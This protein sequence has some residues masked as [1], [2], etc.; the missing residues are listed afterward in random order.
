M[1]KGMMI[2]IIVLILIIGSMTV[3]AKQILKTD[4]YIF[5]YGDDAKHM[6]VY[7]KRDDGRYIYQGTREWPL[8]QWREAITL[9]GTRPGVEI[10]GV[11]IS[12][13]DV[14]A[15]IIAYGATPKPE[16]KPE[17]VFDYETPQL[18]EIEFPPTLEKEDKE[19]LEKAKITKQEMDELNQ[20]VKSI[21]DE[22]AEIEKVGD[23]LDTFLA[24]RPAQIEKDYPESKIEHLSPEERDALIN[25]VISATAAAETAA[26]IT[27]ETEH[28][29]ETGNDVEP[30]DTNP[31]KARELDT[32]SPASPARAAE[33]NTKLSEAD[34]AY[35]KAETELNAAWAAYDPKK[36]ETEK[37]WKD[38]VAKFNEAEEEKR[39]ADVAAQDAQRDLAKKEK[40]SEDERTAEAAARTQRIAEGQTAVGLAQRDAALDGQIYLKK[41]EEKAKERAIDAAEKRNDEIEVKKLEA[42]LEK[43]NEER[44]KLEK[45][46]KDLSEAQVDYGK[47]VQQITDL[48]SNIDALKG[49][50]KDKAPGE[51]EKANN[52]LKAAA[53]ISDEISDLEKQLASAQKQFEDSPEDPARFAAV[54]ELTTQIVRKEGEKTKLENEAKQTKESIESL[55]NSVADLEQQR[56]ELEAKGEN[57]RMRNEISVREQKIAG[58]QAK[59]KTT[60]DKD[61]RAKLEEEIEKLE[62]QNKEDQNT[63]FL[64]ENNWVARWA[65][66]FM[67]DFMQGYEEYKGIGH[68]SSLWIS[69][70]DMAKKRQETAQKF[71]DEILGGVFG[72]KN[73]YQSRICEGLFPREPTQSQNFLVTETSV[74]G[75]LPAASIQAEKS[76]PAMYMEAGK[77]KTKRVYKITYFIENPHMDQELTY[78]IEL[79]GDKTFKS[80]ESKLAGRK[81]EGGREVAGEK[82]GRLGSDPMI[83]ESDSNYDNACLVF[84]PRIMNSNGGYANEICAPIIQY[85]G[86]ATRPYTLPPAMQAAVQNSTGTGTGVSMT[87]A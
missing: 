73:C 72:G 19:I 48:S 76:F 7:T 65:F 68:W 8:D 82:E 47:N 58:L 1:R 64:K 5:V 3:Y 55:K 54:Q 83:F 38:A 31:E 17:S 16:P 80:P 61:D 18:L 29:D 6:D 81:L 41:E 24:E 62:R 44:E 49:I 30:E 71:C 67:A 28:K 12:T 33:T 26:K 27:A 43:L 15:K 59:L 86:A 50:L 22:D 32:G 9:A 36:P 39:L 35:T 11:G 52:Q 84:S 77:T 74:G 66:I 34:A 2:A 69:D 46:K 70:E 87:G 56:K 4:Q 60:T 14:N 79:R 53:T 63:L 21:D 20:L 51:L 85:S 10:S 75:Y 40:A 42:E 13:E 57:L 37:P 78:Y 45:E 25:A 23:M